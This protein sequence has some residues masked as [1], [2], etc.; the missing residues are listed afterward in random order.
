MATYLLIVS[1]VIIMC[2]FFNR[3]TSKLG[4]PMLLAFILLGM[5]FGSDGLLKIHFDN[6]SFA[7][8]VCSTALI[9]IMFYGGFGTKWSEVKPVLVKSVLLSS[10]GVVLTAA[11]TALFCHFV[12]KIEMLESF[13]IGSIISSTDAA[14]VFSILRSKQLNL[15]Y[16]TASLLEVESGSNDPCAYMLTAVV[17]SMM[18]GG[19][20][21]N[22]IFYLIFSQITFGA[23]LG[24]I[25]ASSS[26]WI[27]RRFK[28]SSAGFKAIFV[29]AIAIL[30]YAV[31]EMLGG[32]GYLSTY[33]VGVTIGNC[34]IRNK[35]ALVNFFDGITVLMQMLIF[36]LL[37]LLS[38]PSQLPDV[39]LPALL[40]ALFLTFVA[41][42][43]SVFAILSPFKSNLNQ[44]LLVSWSGLRG[45]ASIVFA[46]MATTS[47]AYTKNDIF[48]IVFFIV[49]FSI[50][51]Q[52]SLLPLISRKLDMID[53]NADVMKTFT[54]YSD[55][56]PI[57]F[58]E[59][60]IPLKHFWVGKKISEI[61]LPP[62]TILVLL[63]RGDKTI[64]PHGRTIILA[65][66]TFILSAKSLGKIEGVSLYEK[67][68][69]K[70]DPWENRSIS[71][72]VKNPNMLIIMIKRKRRIIIPKGS[73]VLR[74][75]DVLVINHIS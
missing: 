55:E 5:I 8:Q 41:R 6:Y 63:Q 46:V 9:F 17:L 3:I 27:L 44:K 2:V 30:S 67:H 25:I 53:E 69:S 75:N 36:F 68:I 48:H 14:S 28:F 34:E 39:A 10:V 29:L 15:K 19:S 71:K 20:N 66:D 72:V 33:I 56:V 59:F 58:I 57:Q 35:K 11:I 74:E 13:L 73:T 51:L 60:T 70:G 22:K 1:V 42:P 38:F 61:S 47:D 16:N 43:I 21:L 32:N 64:V 45:A 4:I 26:L 37:G 52:G 62:D 49:I 7:E 50:L 40:I 31:P 65:G 24:F 12:L 18:G 54:D 23:L